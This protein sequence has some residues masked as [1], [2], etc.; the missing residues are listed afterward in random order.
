MEVAKPVLPRVKDYN[1][2]SSSISH[3]NQ[4]TAEILQVCGF[5]FR[6]SKIVC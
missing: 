3:T 2:G 1:I 4:P 6:T 5:W